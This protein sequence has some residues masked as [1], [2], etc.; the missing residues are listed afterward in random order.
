MIKPSHK[1]WHDKPQN[2]QKILNVKSLSEGSINNDDDLNP[3]LLKKTPKSRRNIILIRHGQYE[4][5]AK[6]SNKQVLTELGNL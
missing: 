3:E 6:E 5:L 2:D 1:P 4:I